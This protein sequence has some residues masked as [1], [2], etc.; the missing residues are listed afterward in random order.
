[1]TEHKKLQPEIRF[2]GFTDD[3]EQR[4]LGEF[5]SS[6]RSGLSRMLD[7]EDIGL[8]VIRANNINNGY[9]DLENDIKYWYQIDPMGANTRNYLVAKDDILINF[10]NSES[11]MGSA[12]IMRS[13]PSRDTI[14]TT[15]ILR[16]RLT[17]D[18]DPYWFYI[19][20]QSKL[21]LEYIKSISKVAV[22]QA[23]FT[24]V[25]FKNF[26]FF[27]PS[28]K[29]QTQIGNFFK[30]LDDTIALHQGTLEKYQKLKV[31]Y[32]E[33]MFPKENELYPELRFPNF[34]DAWEQRKL[35]ELG[36]CQSGIGFPELEQGGKTG[37]PFYK[38]SDMNLLGNEI[39]M[40][41]SNNYVSI[42]QIT[43]KKWKTITSTPA[44]IFAKVGAAL[45]LDRKRLVLNE[46]LIDNNTMAYIFDDSWHYYFGKTLF[47]KTYLPQLSQTGALPSFNAKDVEELNV[48]LPTSKEEQTQIGN[49]FK[50]LDDTIALHQREV[51]KYKKIKQSY[52]EKMFI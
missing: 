27:C 51:E 12:A 34:T 1:M 41:N 26:T 29:E 18:L 24:T 50:Q 49:F 2:A 38:V 35:G 45:M 5:V 11:R 21:Y 8:P 46:F 40:E 22:N 17:S 7:S 37:I 9:V 6:L 52:L 10:I 33:K 42:N 25:E 3:W 32:L 30:Q 4:K 44:V 31:S 15:N 39:F 28:T 20:T 43:N 48:I 23:S 16:L 36:Y 47:D 14:Y 13:I 19:Q